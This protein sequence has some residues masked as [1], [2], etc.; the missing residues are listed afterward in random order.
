MAGGLHIAFP[1]RGC[2]RSHKVI[3]CAPNIPR[4]TGAGCRQHHPRNDVVD[5][6]R[7]AA[8]PRPLREE[9]LDVELWPPTFVAT[10]VGANMKTPAPQARSSEGTITRALFDETFAQLAGKR[11]ANLQFGSLGGVSSV[12]VELGSIAGIQ[13][14]SDEEIGWPGGVVA[15]K[16]KAG[17]RNVVGGLTGGGTSQQE[18][19]SDT[20][21]CH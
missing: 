7:P 14:E 1:R 20:T 6:S 11:F 19:T 3:E 2:T 21:R 17:I 16:A 5:S 8:A 13:E 18:R 15:T 4:L 9:I 12:Q 10:K